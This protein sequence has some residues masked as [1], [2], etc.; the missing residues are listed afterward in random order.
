MTVALSGIGLALPDHS[1]S[2]DEAA[3][4][5]LVHSTAS[6]RER[7][8]APRLYQ[9]SGVE[10]RHLVVLR[11]PY[12]QGQPQHALYEPPS[13]QR[14]TGPTTA[15]RMQAYARYAPALSI[16]A[17]QRAIGSAQVN[18]KTITHLVTVSCSGFAAPGVDIELI[19]QLGL[20]ADVARTQVGFMGCHGALNGLRVAEAFVRADP[21][22]VVLVLAIELCSLHY[23]YAWTNQNLVSNALFAD[24]AAATI[25]RSDRSACKA[26][27]LGASSATIVPDTHDAMTWRI[28]DHGFSMTLSSR[29]PE[30]IHQELPGFMGSWL[31]R[32]GLTMDEVA[33]WAIHPGGPRILQA[34]RDALNLSDTALRASQEILRQHGNMSSPTILFVLDRLRELGAAGPVVALGFGPGLAIEGRL[35]HTGR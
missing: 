32:A 13:E 21:Q 1:I 27:E 16:K 3:R 24:G 4:R 14:P 33:A 26:W 17:C 15:D 31:D 5:S 19:Q 30:L 10:K 28:G 2:Q 8:L 34:T 18:A 29:V 25:V 12:V 6:Q 22:A 20:R 35:L 7:K 11:E 9:K 23:Q